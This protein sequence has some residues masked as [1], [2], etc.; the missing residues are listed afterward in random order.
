MGKKLSLEEVL[1]KFNEVH[2][3]RYDYSSVVFKSVD[4][5]VEIFCNQKGHGFFSQRPSKHFKGQGCPKCGIIKRSQSKKFKINDVIN[6]FKEVHSNYYDYTFV[7]YKNSQIKVKIVCPKHGAFFQTPDN[8]WNGNGCN[9][10]ASIRGGILNRKSQDEFL[11]QANKIHSNK[12]DYSLVEYQTSE[13]KIKIIC[14][15]GGHGIFEMKPANHFNGQGCPRCGVIKRTISR[16][17]S[18]KDFIEQAKLIHTNKNYGYEK[19]EYKGNKRKVIITCPV[20]GDFEKNPTKHLDGQGCPVCG[21]LEGRFKSRLSVDEF[22]SRSIEIHNNYYN[23]KNVKYVNNS[24]NVEIVC[25]VHGNFNQVPA[26][27]LVGRGCPGCGIEE[28]TKAQTKTNQKF[29]DEAKLIH[30]GRYYYDKVEYITAKQKVIIT[31]KEHGDFLQDPSGHLSGKGCVRCLNKKEGRLAII[32]NEIGVVY[33][34]HRIKN[35]L[36]DFF[37]PEY[38]LI[39]ERD[40][41]QH[42][43]KEIKHW[44]S[45]NNHKIDIEKTE[46]AKSNGFRICRIPYWLNEDNERKEIRNILDGKPTYPDIPDLEQAKTKPLPN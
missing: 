8:H 24:T 11:Q 20:H 29:I 36:F 19:V 35:R 2:G 30:K 23:Y 44:N 17:K 15:E 9:R 18:T 38:N 43:T 7:E 41:E 42:Y 6:R 12:Y 16:T 27:H 31:C 22:I 5:N 10:C 34:N 33:R 1:K 14:I 40:G 28:R 32:L 45:R 25:P 39:I 21:D 46:L 26:S 4:F 37:L 13:N 3:E